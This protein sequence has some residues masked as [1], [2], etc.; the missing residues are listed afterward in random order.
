MRT[1]VIARY[2]VSLMLRHSAFVGMKYMPFKFFLRRPEIRLT[3][4]AM[5]VYCQVYVSY[6]YIQAAE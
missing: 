6:T 2:V 1:G 5:L 3:Q 4:S